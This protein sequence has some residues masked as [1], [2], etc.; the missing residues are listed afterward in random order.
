MPETKD[1]SDLTFLTLRRQA[2]LGLEGLVGC[3]AGCF[4]AHAM[5]EH[6]SMRVSMEVGLL[7]PL[8]FQDFIGLAAAGGVD[9]DAVALFL[10]DDGAGD[11]R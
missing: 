2:E 5:R 3:G 10:A 4:E 8:H 11:G 7:S 9:L 6:L 1:A